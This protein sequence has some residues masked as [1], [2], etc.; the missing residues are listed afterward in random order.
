M[1]KTRVVVDASVLLAAV[2]PDPPAHKEYV[3]Q[4]LYA[5]EK[6]D[7]EMVMI[8][9]CQHEMAAKLITKVRG[10]FISR[11]LVDEFLENIHDLRWSLDVDIR[12][13]DELFQDA[14]RLGCRGYDAAYLRAALN[15]GAELATLDKA[16][17]P[18]M[19]TAKV[20]HWQP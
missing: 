6:G 9:L 2:L 13:V 4:F 18:H 11:R 7:I 14:N 17:L 10:N 8:Q 19:K 1:T 5:F 3:R 16:L 12:Q 20:T 15:C